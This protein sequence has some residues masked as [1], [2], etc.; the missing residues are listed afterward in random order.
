MT[1][2]KGTS[3]RDCHSNASKDKVPPLPIPPRFKT[4]PPRRD[5]HVEKDIEIAL[6]DGRSNDE[7]MMQFQY[8]GHVVLITV[9]F[10]LHI[11]FLAMCFPVSSDAR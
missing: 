9:S 7:E 6:A 1:T 5:E 2:R 10:L 8:S 3:K 11:V 4:L